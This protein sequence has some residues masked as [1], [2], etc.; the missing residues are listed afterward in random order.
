M[1]WAAIQDGVFFAFK[2]LDIYI[3]TNLF[4]FNY[5]FFFMSAIFFWR[6]LKKNH[7]NLGS[8]SYA[9]AYVVLQPISS[10]ISPSIGFGSE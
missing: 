8:Q 1:A 3:Q 4:S 5:Y 9:P 6:P 10:L 2:N 7:Q